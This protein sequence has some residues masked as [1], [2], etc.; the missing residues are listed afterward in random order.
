LYS[1]ETC[2]GASISMLYF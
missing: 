2:L 1:V